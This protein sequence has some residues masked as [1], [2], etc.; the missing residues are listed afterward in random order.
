[1]ASPRF[2]VGQTFTIDNKEVTVTEE[3]IKSDDWKAR[4]T[5]A[6]LSTQQ[7]S[8]HEDSDNSEDSDS[9]DSDSSDDEVRRSDLRQYPNADPNQEFKIARLGSFYKCHGGCK[10]T[11]LKT[12]KVE[13]W[14]GG[15]TRL[16]SD[17]AL[18]KL[19]YKSDV[20]T[21]LYVH[22]YWESRPDPDMYWV[23]DLIDCN[24][25]YLQEHC[26]CVLSKSVS[27]LL[28]RMV[29]AEVAHAAAK[30]R[31]APKSRKRKRH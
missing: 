16:V 22:L 26:E 20:W 4:M 25:E 1:M 31:A 3:N 12:G 6:L 7:S 28:C 10:Q 21:F 24:P 11:D 30:H 15:F 9:S 14:G 13:R 29:D 17:E 5:R 19:L 27:D 23:W 2:T 8:N 18:M